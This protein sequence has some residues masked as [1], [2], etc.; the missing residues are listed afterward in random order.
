MILGIVIAIL[1]LAALIVAISFTAVSRA[2]GKLQGYTTGKIVDISYYPEGFNKGQ[3][4]E[5]AVNASYATNRQQ[6][7][8]ATVYAYVV[9]G[10]EY[11]RATNYLINEGAA[12]KKIGQECKVRYNRNHPA[13]A[14]IAKSGVFR[15]I[16]TALYVV[17][18]VLIEIG[19][20]VVVSM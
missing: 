13:E 17:A 2:N 14:S 5:E 8:A 20:I 3:G 15:T 6:H 4:T 10:V 19:L 9:D 1:G 18:V 7:I 11:R 16:A 12:K